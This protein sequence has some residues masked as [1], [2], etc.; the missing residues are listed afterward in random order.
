MNLLIWMLAGGIVGG[1]SYS[2]LHYN[3]ARGRN[4]SILIG[5]AG[6]LLGGKMIAPLF[7]AAGAPGDFSLAALLFAAAAAA[8]CLALGNL[9]QNRWG[10]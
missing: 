4:I 3:E 2:F 6:G 1:A 8:A 9:V 5:A 10:V 7:I